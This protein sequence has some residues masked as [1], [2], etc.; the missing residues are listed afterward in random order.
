MHKMLE[1]KQTGILYH[2]TFFDRLFE[3]TDGWKG[4]DPVI[5]MGLDDIDN[6]LYSISTTRKFDFLWGNVRFAL[7]GEK[8]SHRFKISPVAFFGRK[9]END[10][11]T[12][13]DQYEERIVSNSPT[14]LELKKYC[15]EVVVCTSA[16]YGSSITDEELQAAKTYFEGLGIPFRSIE[17]ETDWSK[18]GTVRTLK[19]KR[20]VDWNALLQQVKSES[21]VIKNYSQFLNE[22]FVPRMDRDREAGKAKL[23]AAHVKQAKEVQALLRN[24]SMDREEL[25]KKIAPMLREIRSEAERERLC[26]FALEILYKYFGECEVCVLDPKLYEPENYDVPGVY[27]PLHYMA[28]FYRGALLCAFEDLTCFE[29]SS[30]LMAEILDSVGEINVGKGAY[31]LKH[32]A[33]K[34]LRFALASLV[35]DITAFSPID[36]S[37]TLAISNWRRDG[38]LVPVDNI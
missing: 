31:N 21:C 28:V 33:S 8:I 30:Q 3:M 27:D 10:D 6:R 32:V 7:D 2:F 17:S 24:F 37:N 11:K 26:Y 1:A 13:N 9:P 35:D 15:L 22:T 18:Y 5:K 23:Y 29:I 12:V 16:N 4:S 20:S 25:A 36:I 19:P 38:V 34:Y 14:G